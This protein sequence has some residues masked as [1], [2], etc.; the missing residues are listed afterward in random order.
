MEEVLAFFK[1][2][3]TYFLATINGDQPE[4]RPFGTISE[5]NGKL[6]IQTGKVKDCFKQIEANP[7][8]SIC[9]FDPETGTWC[10][11]TATAEINDSVEAADALLNEYP[12]LRKMYT[13][14]DGNT[15]LIGLTNAKARFCSFT[16][17]ERDVEF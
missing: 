8:I 11:V 2:N 10:R 6:Y 13:P 16:A 7:K 5:Y 12:E 14:G 4:V 9:G 15:V 17:P 1:K 3:P